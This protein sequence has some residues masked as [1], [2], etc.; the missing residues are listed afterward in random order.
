MSYTRFADLKPGQRFVFCYGWPPRPDDPPHAP[1]V[2]GHRLWYIDDK[3]RR[4]MTG[5]G[6]AV[7]AVK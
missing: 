5:A 4:F 6:A 2:K 7:Q 1:F 3:G